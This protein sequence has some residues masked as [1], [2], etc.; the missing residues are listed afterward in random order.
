[1]GIRDD[2]NNIPT[3]NTFKAWKL[4]ADPDDVAAIEEACRDTT[5]NPNQIIL[6]CKRNNIPMSKETVRQYR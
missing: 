5:I 1:M 4:T 2:L 3:A 6:A